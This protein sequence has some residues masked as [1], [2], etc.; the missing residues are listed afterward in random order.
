MSMATFRSFPWGCSGAQCANEESAASDRAT[1]SVLEVATFRMGGDQ[2]SSV[3]KERSPAI[4][5]VATGACKQTD[6][7]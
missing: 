7:R 5:Y 3:A 4:R 6:E 2:R 1:W